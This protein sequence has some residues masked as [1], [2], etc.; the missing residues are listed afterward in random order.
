MKLLNPGYD[1]VSVGG[2]LYYNAKS[3]TCYNGSNNAPTSCDFTSTGLKNDTT[4]N[5][6]ETVV[7]NLGGTNAYDTSTAS[8][9][10]TAERGTTLYSGSPTTW[11]GKVGLMYPS[12]YGYATGGSSNTSRAT[13]LAKELY[14]WD[15]VSDCYN[16]D[17]LF[18]SAYQW[19]LA[20]Y[21][22]IGFDVFNVL[23]VGYVNSDRANYDFGVRPALYLKSSIS[24][25]SGT[26]ES[27][28]PYRLK[29]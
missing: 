8:M 4:R 6:I 18:N 23:S 17:Y 7:W 29:F 14:N 25:D 21:S 1:S 11:T 5:A 12:D 19:T 15:S 3:G 20:P 26:G 22:G 28:N 16:N 27:S 9:F 13:C 10:Y 2:S 24:A